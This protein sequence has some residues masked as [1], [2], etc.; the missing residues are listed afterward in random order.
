MRV[1]KPS[2]GKRVM[3]LMPDSPAVSFAQLSV[4]PAPSD[5]T[6][7]RPVTTTSGRPFC[8][9]PLSSFALLSRCARP[10]R[11]LR[12]ASARRRS[13]RLE[14][15]PR[16]LA[17]PNRSSH[18]AETDYHDQVRPWPARCSWG[19]AAPTRDR[20]MIRW[21]ARQDRS[22]APENAAPLRLQDWRLSP[23]T[24]LRHGRYLSCP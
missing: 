24:I 12:L 16:S 13:P 2:V 23:L 18:T 9:C 22:A 7:P 17:A 8:L 3:A 20:D 4:L 1:F 10:A 6:M 11:G 5:V 15:H 21:H 19:I 14:I